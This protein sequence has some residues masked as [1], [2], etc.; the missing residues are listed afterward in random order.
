MSKLQRI[1]C[2]AVAVQLVSAAA[3]AQNGAT[4]ATSGPAAVSADAGLVEYSIGPEDVLGVVFWR[5]TD[6]TGD[7]TVRPDGRIT[8]PL[9]GE[10]RAAEP[11]TA[12]ARR[13]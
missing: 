12:A 6:M 3:S 1:L 9:I 13:R 10:L 2:L 5:D 8:L 11:R 7:V 4:R